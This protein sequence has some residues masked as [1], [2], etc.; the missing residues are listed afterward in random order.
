MELR[1]SA[2]K[3]IQVRV[4]LKSQPETIFYIVYN[5]YI[6]TYIYILIHI[7]YFMIFYVNQQLQCSSSKAIQTLHSLLCLSRS[8]PGE[9]MVFDDGSMTADKAQSSAMSGADA[10]HR[11][12]RVVRF[13]E[14]ED[15][16]ETC[17][18]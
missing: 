14:A 17:W 11:S 16:D 12:L 10:L 15:M 5:I 8:A 6:Y 13:G 1:L 2:S 18:V 4:H 3:E 7:D 9:L